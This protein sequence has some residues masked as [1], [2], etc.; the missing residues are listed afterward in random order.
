MEKF[1]KKIESD[2]PALIFLPDKG[3]FYMVGAIWVENTKKFFD[4]IRKWFNKYFE[5]PNKNGSTFI[6]RLI[7]FNSTSSR[8]L[9]SLLKDLYQESQKQNHKLKIIWEYFIDDISSNAMNEDE[10]EEKF[11]KLLKTLFPPEFIELRARPAHIALKIEKIANKN[12][13]TSTR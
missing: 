2:S 6:F 7:Y 12:L 1:L 13:F 3:I 4:P 10:V 5:S 9:L 8:E 11:L